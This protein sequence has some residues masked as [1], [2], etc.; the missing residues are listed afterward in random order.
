[1][2]G[3]QVFQLLFVLQFGCVMSELKEVKTEDVHLHLYFTS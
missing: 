1:M 3:A 2:D